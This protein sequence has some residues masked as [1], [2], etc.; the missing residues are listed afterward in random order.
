MLLVSGVKPRRRPR[1]KKGDVR[2]KAAVLEIGAADGNLVKFTVYAT[3]K[4]GV[5]R[6]EQG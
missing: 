5:R 6:G 2:K 4:D 3:Q 1:S